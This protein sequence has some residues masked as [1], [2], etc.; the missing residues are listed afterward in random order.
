VIRL[1]E[2]SHRRAR[3]LTASGAP[4]YLAVNPVEYHGPHLS[5][6]NDAHVSL[7]LVR[8]VHA[9]LATRHDWPLLFAGELGLGVDPVPGPGSRPVSLA[10]VRRAV[11]RACAALVALGSRRLV[12]V[13]F[14]G[15][16]LHNLAL[17]A[18]VE[19]L[20][21]RGVPSLAPMHLLLRELL[22]VT[23]EP[24][25]A[26]YDHIE[27]PGE[28]AAMIRGLPLDFHAG[29]AETSLALHH[30]PES[31]SDRLDQVPPCPRPEPVAWLARAAALARRAGRTTLADE[32][33]F[34]ARA[35]G[36][37]RLR[38]FPGYTGSPHL[39]RASAG[40]VFSEIISARFAAAAEAV[41][42]EGAP[43][44]PPVMG[45]LGPLT[46]G[47]RLGSPHVV[48]R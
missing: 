30:A 39:A 6:E 7:G 37:Y 3:A 17:E 45:W 1:L 35:M 48:E 11:Q 5:L 23:G 34:A 43:P 47:G 41:L 14:H 8:E 25:A 13:S 31:V 15:S 44:P 10:E 46:L 19:L 32:L 12:L 29:Y 24:F 2:Q 36:W 21:R 20:R 26:A 18:G 27:D 9:L 16:P 40:R 28:R 33:A 4:V 22:T 38:P 42:V